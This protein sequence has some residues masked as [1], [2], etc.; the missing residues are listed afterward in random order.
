MLEA[1]VKTVLN[2]KVLRN[3]T[4]DAV[5]DIINGANANQNN[6]LEEF[7]STKFDNSIQELIVNHSASGE[8]NEIVPKLMP[9]LNN[10]KDYREYYMT[11]LYKAGNISNYI[12]IV[13]ISPVNAIVMFSNAIESDNKDRNPS[14]NKKF[15]I[16]YLVNNALGYI[17][18]EAK[19]GKSK[20][21]SASVMNEG[22]RRINELNKN[23]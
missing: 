14:F 2:D 5:C 9:L 1:I 23:S 19:T 11:I 8:L 13:A 10:V 3:R 21:I 18:T 22:W 12:R 16:P 15:R 6:L 17:I 7:D 20:A 4:P